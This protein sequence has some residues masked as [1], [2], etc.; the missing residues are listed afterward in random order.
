MKIY[1]VN[2]L[3]EEIVKFAEKL[4]PVDCLS[5]CLGNSISAVTGEAGSFFAID[6]NGTVH[7]VDYVGNWGRCYLGHQFGK[8][9]LDQVELVY[10]Y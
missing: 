5:I 8:V 4:P 1:D 3:K 10:V 2:N 6:K 7:H 9:D